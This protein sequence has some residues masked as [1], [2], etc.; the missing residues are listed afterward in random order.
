VGKRTISDWA[1]C[2]QLVALPN[3]GDQKPSTLRDKM[4]AL[5]PVDETPGKPFI[6]GFLQRLPVYM[7]QQLATQP[8]MDLEEP[9]ERADRNWSTSGMASWVAA[10][11]FQL[12]G[13]DIQ[14]C[15]FN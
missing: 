10:A 14:H 12:G 6:T 5:Q 4:K 9:V 2:E 8:T 15:S 13:L 11:L 7:R 1:K 3:L